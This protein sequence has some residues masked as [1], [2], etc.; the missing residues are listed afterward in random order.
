MSRMTLAFPIAASLSLLLAA[1]C[2]DDDTPP[3]DAAPADASTDAPVGPEIDGAVDAPVTDGAI[4]GTPVDVCADPLPCAAPSAGHVTL[5]GQLFDLGTSAAIQAD[6]PTGAACDLGN[7][8]DPCSLTVLAFDVIEVVSNPTDPQPLD[9]DSIVVDDCGRFQVIDAMAPTSTRVALLAAPIAG[10]DYRRAGIVF[11]ATSGQAVDGL[12]LHALSSAT[13][14][15][16]S[17]A[18][19]LEGDTFASLGVIVG[20]FTNAGT[21]VDG[22]TIQTGT[23]TQF[24]AD[25]F[26][27]DD[28]DPASR[29][30]V[31]PAATATGAN[32]TA[33]LI[34][35]PSIGLYTGSTPPDGCTWPSAQAATIAGLVFVQPFEASCP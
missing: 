5:C 6:A 33:L 12:E 29:L 23:G 18:A 20:I 15:A 34:D 26:Y 24:P 1:G 22:V 21:P 2:G 10:D 25:D 28:T 35:H 4:D 32:G 13:D 9:A 27:F 11:G 30:S 19:G 16:W 14:A 31:N 17:A 3:F 8:A 7:P